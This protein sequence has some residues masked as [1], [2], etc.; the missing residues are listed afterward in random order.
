MRRTRRRTMYGAAWPDRSL[1]HRYCRAVAA[2]R[3]LLEHP[4]MSFEIF[5]AFVVFALVALFTPGPN[6]L[7]LMASGL[8]FGLRRAMPHF[9]GVILGF[10][11]MVL[12]VGNS[13]RALTSARLEVNL[14]AIGAPKIVACWAD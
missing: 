14:A 4:F 2:R 7:M 9:W 3:T 13:S 6:N 12:V 1:P 10:A 5:G 8:N 11:F